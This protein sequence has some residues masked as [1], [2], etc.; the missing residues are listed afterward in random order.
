[1][2]FYPIFWK[3]MMLICILTGERIEA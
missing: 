2:I 3:E 1:M